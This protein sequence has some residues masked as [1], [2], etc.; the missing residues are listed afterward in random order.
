MSSSIQAADQ[1]SD[2]QP[3]AIDIHFAVIM[4]A[5]ARPGDHQFLLPKLTSLAGLAAQVYTEWT[6]IAIGDGLWADEIA[7]FFQA[8]DDAQIPRHKVVFR[9]MDVKHREEIFYRNVSF[10]MSSS[11]WSFA[12][13]NAVNLGLDIAAALRHVTHVAR[14]DDDDRWLPQ[15]LSVLADAYHLYPEASFAYTQVEGI[16]ETPFPEY[17]E[18]MPYI[19]APLPCGFAH[20]TSSWDLRSAAGTLRYRQQHEQ[21]AD[22]RTMSSC[23]GQTPCALVL[24]YDADMWERVWTLVQTKQLVALFVPQLTAR[25]TNSKLKKVKLQQLQPLVSSGSMNN[26]GALLHCADCQIRCNATEL[27]ATN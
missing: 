26:A 22:S 19:R 24:S 14:L 18:G 6:I 10:V 12:G 27:H 1:C 16:G 9:N 2:V 8:L 23:C 4:S 21:Q 20:T 13:A 15:H 17:P 5:F 7:R 3:N 25:Y 11:V